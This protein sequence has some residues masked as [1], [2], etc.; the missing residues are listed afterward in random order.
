MKKAPNAF[1]QLL[2]NAIENRLPISL[3]LSAAY[4]IV[5]RSLYPIQTADPMLQMIAM[6]RPGSLPR[7][8]LELHTLSFQYAVPCALN[9]VLACLRPLLYAGPQ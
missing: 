8:C 1:Q 2:R 4:G 5:L 6:V 3:G 9:P 7:L